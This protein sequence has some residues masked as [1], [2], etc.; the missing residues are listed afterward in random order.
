MQEYTCSFAFSRIVRSATPPFPFAITSSIWFYRCYLYAASLNLSWRMSVMFYSLC[1][2]LCTPPLP[3]RT[4]LSD[5]FLSQFFRF[6]ILIEGRHKRTISKTSV[7][8]CVLT[9][10]LPIRLVGFLKRF[11]FIDA[12]DNF[13]PWIFFNKTF[14]LFVFDTY[15]FYNF[16]KVYCTI[17]VV[18]FIMD[19][20][21][22]FSIISTS[23]S[24]WI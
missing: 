9:N 17:S 18:F 4:A 12:Y 1:I 10:A 20:A 14:Q 19:E 15:F 23:I 6:F 22:R 5:K 3:C 16:V 13:G 11:L 8:W 21:L 7:P 2:Y 24:I